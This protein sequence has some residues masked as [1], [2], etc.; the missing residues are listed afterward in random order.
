MDYRNFKSLNVKYSGALSREDY[1]K[2][3]FSNWHDELMSYKEKNGITNIGFK[4]L[5]YSYFNN[6][7]SEK[8]CACGND[9]KFYSI[10]K[11]Y[12]LYCGVSCSNKGN[13]ETI[14]KVK[15]EKYGDPNYNNKNKFRGTP[16]VEEHA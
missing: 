7:T 14:K 4:E 10:D 13:V 1:I 11:G 5:L 16:S 6:D 9:L 3:N 12:S 8:K 2:R 15:L